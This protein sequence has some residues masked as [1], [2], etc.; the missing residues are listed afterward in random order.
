MF[1]FNEK[2]FEELH[3]V[4]V[5]VK[6]RIHNGALNVVL[7]SFPFE[8]FIELNVSWRECFYVVLTWYVAWVLIHSQITSKIL[9][10]SLYTFYTNATSKTHESIARV[11]RYN[12]TENKIPFKH[13]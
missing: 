5:V 11:R 12:F 10:H 8:C 7:E 6:F 1:I 13:H 3:D 9:K 2:V 4:V